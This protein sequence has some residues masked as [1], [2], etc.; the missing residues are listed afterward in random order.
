MVTGAITIVLLGFVVAVAARSRPGISTEDP[1]FDVNSR[2]DIDITRLLAWIIIVMAVLGAV[3]FALGLKQ[4]KP[5]DDQR[6]RSYLGLFLGVVAFFLIFRY[7]RPIADNLLNQEAVSGTEEAVDQVGSGSSGSSGWLF[8]LLLAAIVA[9]ALTRVGLAVRDGDPSFEP[10]QSAPELA[11]T[12]PQAARPRATAGLGADPRS[13]IFNAYFQ[14]EDLAGDGGVVRRPTETANR[15]ASRAARELQLNAE[16]VSALSRSYS[17]ARF[18][19]V[20]P[21]TEDAAEVERIA[22]MIREKITP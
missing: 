4:T 16:Q 8:S 9:A 12:I 11:L 7:V 13:R 21:T 6:K 18:G 20:A 1:L 3:L 10:E 2:F 17:R 5:R 22:R 19:F 14:F 15:H